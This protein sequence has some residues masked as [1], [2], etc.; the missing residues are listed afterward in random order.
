MA[1]KIAIKSAKLAFTN[2]QAAIFNLNDDPE[3][4]GMGGQALRVILKS[5]ADCYIGFD[6]AANTDDYL[7]EASDDPIAVFG[8][9]SKISALGKTGAGNLY[10]IAMA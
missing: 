1:T 6:T 9:V 5:D 4:G 3:V 10:I 2:S 8:Q 7:I